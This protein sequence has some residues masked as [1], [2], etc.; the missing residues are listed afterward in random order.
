VTDRR[1]PRDRV[2][3]VGLG[4]TATTYSLTLMRYGAAWSLLAGGAIIAN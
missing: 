2:A 3:F 4:H 1:R